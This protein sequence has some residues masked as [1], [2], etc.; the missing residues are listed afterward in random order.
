MLLDIYKRVDL[1]ITS[2]TPI[3]VDDDEHK[4][5][6]VEKLQDKLGLEFDF[7]QQIFNGKE[8]L[9]DKWLMNIKGTKVPERKEYR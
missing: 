9:S 6:M 5:K 2:E 1:V 3:D 7:V 8:V 4:L